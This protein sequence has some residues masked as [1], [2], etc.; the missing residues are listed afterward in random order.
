MSSRQNIRV[1]SACHFL[2]SVHSLTRDLDEGISSRKGGKNL[3]VYHPDWIL[4][5]IRKERRLPPLKR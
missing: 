2:K 1:R 4:E 3:D 5:S